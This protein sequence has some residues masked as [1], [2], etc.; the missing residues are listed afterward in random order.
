MNNEITFGRGSAKYRIVVE[1]YCYRLDKWKMP[2][3]K[4]NYWERVGWYSDLYFLF[5]KLTCLGVMEAGE[6]S[7]IMEVV[8]QTCDELKKNVYEA[9]GSPPSRDK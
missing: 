2:R 3:G 8:K 5:Y 6:Y 9:L 1:P 4:D 7:N